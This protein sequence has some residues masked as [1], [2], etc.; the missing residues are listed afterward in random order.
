MRFT[1]KCLRV[2]LK[3]WMITMD[4]TIKDHNNTINRASKII[5][6]HINKTKNLINNKMDKS[7]SM[8]KT[9]SITIKT[10]R[11]TR[12]IMMVKKGMMNN[13]NKRV[14]ELLLI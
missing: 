6:N 7:T 14:V 8:I 11:A 3:M 2:L 9:N 13:I 5:N 1:H 4:S 12:D 10:N